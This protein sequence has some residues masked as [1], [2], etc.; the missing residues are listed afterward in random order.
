MSQTPVSHYRSHAK[1]HPQTTTRPVQR[2]L[3]GEEKSRKVQGTIQ[4]GN[5]ASLKMLPPDHQVNHSH[6]LRCPPHSN[7]F[8]MWAMMITGGTCA[9]GSFCTLRMWPLKIAVRLRCSGL[10]GGRGVRLCGEG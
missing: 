10:S 2:T 3:T 6:Q 9:P 4:G 1:T 5:V 8:V 7:I